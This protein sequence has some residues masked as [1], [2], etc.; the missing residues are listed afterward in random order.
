M[1]SNTRLQDFYNIIYPTKNTPLVRL[2][3]NLPTIW[4]TNKDIW[5]SGMELPSMPEMYTVYSDCKGFNISLLLHYDQINRHPS[6][7]NKEKDK[8]VGIR[9]ACHL[10][11]KLLHSYQFEEM[12]DIEKVFTLLAIRHNSSLKMKKLALRKIQ[13]LVIEHPQ[14]SLYLRFYQATI[15]DVHNTKKQMGF[16]AEKPQ[17]EYD[18]HAIDEILEEPTYKEIVNVQEKRH[19]L[20][21]LSKSIPREIHELLRE[22]KKFAISISGGG[23]SMLMAYYMNIY[24]KH[25]NIDMILLHISYNNRDCCDTEIEFLNQ[26]AYTVLNVPL[27]VYR[28]DEIVRSRSTKVR[29]LYEE[30]TRKIRFSFYDYFKCPIMLGH[31]NDD[32]VENMFSNMIK[33]IHFDNLYGM[34]SVSYESDICIMRPM[35]SFDKSY[36]TKCA[37]E[38]NISYLEDSTPPWSQRGKMRDSLIPQIKSFHKDILPGL[39]AFVEHSTLLHKNWE[40]MFSE[41]LSTNTKKER[42]TIIINRT[43]EFFKLNYT[44]IQFWIDIWFGHDMVTRPSNKSI[45]NMIQNI[46]SFK[47]PILCNLNKQ[48]NAQ[49]NDETIIITQV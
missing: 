37:D 45:R 41:F 36:I 12:D 33:Q 6:K 19:I 13:K 5:F 2:I 9:F 14:S 31:N 22:K 4:K 27:Y 21:E 35:L 24:A 47:R 32:R 49:I 3:P 29:A 40:L 20:S 17:N 26:Y 48:F 23:D 30:V 42:N 25:H 44:S 34:K 18:V 15:M 38:L 39:S 1:T 10:A 16:K 28:I 43:S 8:K 7:L 46:K 11:L